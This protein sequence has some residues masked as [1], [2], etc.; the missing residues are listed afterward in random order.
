MI[1]G[2][3]GNQSA[4]KESVK[5]SRSEWS[6][7][8]LQQPG[9]MTP[10]VPK[11]SST[12]V[13][14]VKKSLSLDRPS[15]RMAMPSQ[16]YS[17]DCDAMMCSD[18]ILVT[19]NSFMSKDYNQH[20][21]SDFK[22][23]TRNSKEGEKS[24]RETI[25]VGFKCDD[26]VKFIVNEVESTEV[27]A[28]HKILNSGVD[29]ARNKTIEAV[30]Q[31]DCDKTSIDVDLSCKLRHRMSLNREHGE[32]VCGSGDPCRSRDADNH[33]V[34]SRSRGSSDVSVD[35]SVVLRNE[36][37]GSRDK[38]EHE[39]KRKSSETRTDKEKKYGENSKKDVSGDSDKSRV[40]V[41]GEETHYKIMKGETSKVNTV[42]GVEKQKMC[43]MQNVESVKQSKSQSLETRRKPRLTK[44]PSVTKEDSER[45]KSLSLESRD[46]DLLEMTPEHKSQFNWEGVELQ[47]HRVVVAAR[48][49]WFRRAL[50]SGMREAIDR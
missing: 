48:C 36:L 17:L 28:K 2:H 16:A 21:V 42:Y 20:H 18:N 5:E 40:A 33:L 30:I 45:S 12:V 15:V 47:A 22:F 29:E 50:L 24:N 8:Q 4:N 13:R 26:K 39:V 35:Q 34:R 9:T 11:V 43:E 10:S 7:L 3:E 25:D 6:E 1:E 38:R 49:E 31:A 27:S 23:A 32:D 14:K 44:T 46:E 19:S 37:E 41:S